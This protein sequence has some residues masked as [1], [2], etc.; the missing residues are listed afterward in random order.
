MRQIWSNPF[1]QEFKAK[2][3]T[4]K[5]EFI[6]QVYTL[7]IKFLDGGE[8]ENLAYMAPTAREATIN[9]AKKLGFD[10]STERKYT[11]AKFDSSVRDVLLSEDKY[12]K[13]AKALY[14]YQERRGQILQR[15]YVPDSIR[16]RWKRELENTL[17]ERNGVI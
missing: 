6:P 15:H 7:S 10:N 13:E 5:S 2:Y 1:A 17:V 3:L 12:L 11:L 9:G 8:E 16:D 14:L 4:Q